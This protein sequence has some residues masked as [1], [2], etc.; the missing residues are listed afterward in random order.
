MMVRGAAGINLSG[1]KHIPV[2][3][4][5]LRKFPAGIDR[6]RARLADEMMLDKP[7]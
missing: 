2:Y 3:M 6:V 5:V 1:S 4:Y 7:G